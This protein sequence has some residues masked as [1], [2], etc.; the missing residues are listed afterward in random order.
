MAK[1]TDISDREWELYRERMTRI[2]SWSLRNLRRGTGGPEDAVQSALR[3]FLNHSSDEE[4]PDDASD[5]WNLL[6]HH[7]KRKISKYA[8]QPRSRKNKA[9]RMGD[10]AT[11]AELASWKEH[12]A[13]SNISP[14]EV[15]DFVRAA[16][17][18]LEEIIADPELRQIACLKLECFTHEE[19]VEIMPGMSVDKVSRRLSRIRQLLRSHSST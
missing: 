4:F 13:T 14:E 3:T 15:E 8:N 17:E 6:H 9:I 19:I 12:F 16:V 5:V 7:L 2:A 11:D 1:S 10:L 18:S